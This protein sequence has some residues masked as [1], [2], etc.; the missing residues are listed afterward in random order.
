MIS[1]ELCLSTSVATPAGF[2]RAER[3]AL[4]LLIQR[5][6]VAAGGMD[7]IADFKVL[8]IQSGS[9]DSCYTLACCAPRN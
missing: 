5:L 3:T 2:F 9:R 1:N 6:A 8:A 4:Q 7:Q